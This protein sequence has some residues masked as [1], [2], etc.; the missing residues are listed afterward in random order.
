M[1]K[2]TKRDESFFPVNLRV[3]TKKCKSHSG[4]LRFSA[5]FSYNQ[6]S[7]PANL[8]ASLHNKSSGSVGSQECS[9]VDSH[10]WSA[11]R[12]SARQA[13]THRRSRGRA[14]CTLN[15]PA[16]HNND[17]SRLH[18]VLLSLFLRFTAVGATRA[19]DGLQGCCQG[20]F[21]VLG[22]GV[23]LGGCHIGSA[24]TGGPAGTS[25]IV[26]NNR[27]LILLKHRAGMLPPFF[28]FLFFTTRSFLP[29]RVW[30]CLQTCSNTKLPNE[31]SV[32]NNAGVCQDLIISG[33]SLER[34]F[35]DKQIKLTPPSWLL[36]KPCSIHED[37]T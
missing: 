6:S 3:N 30:G 26:N 16:C 2:I 32:M 35:A 13:Q 28:F 29:F 21:N 14:D 22:F 24:L 8:L 15:K 36:R 7:F 10:S 12:D 9:T 17:G 27:I 18:Y 20:E 1:N 5:V 23:F 19:W 34:K 31:P 4:S 33:I 11:C 37:K 25:G